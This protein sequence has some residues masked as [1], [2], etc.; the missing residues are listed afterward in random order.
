MNNTVR[1]L[2]LW[3][4]LWL[5]FAEPVSALAEL[6]KY[7][8]CCTDE[9]REDSCP[10]SCVLCHCCLHRVSVEIAPQ[11]ALL[12]ELLSARVTETT[13]TEPAS[14]DPQERSPVPIA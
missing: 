11:A 7:D 3:T 2:L 6:A 5:A 10:P 13:K 1:G 9:T 12:S 14:P 4:S 8:G